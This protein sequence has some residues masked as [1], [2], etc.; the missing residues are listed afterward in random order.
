[1]TAYRQVIG[2]NQPASRRV[3]RFHNHQVL[4][5]TGAREESLIQ[6]VLRAAGPWD[7]WKVVGGDSR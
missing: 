4:E 3:S 5:S 2:L 1:M 7:F 6:N